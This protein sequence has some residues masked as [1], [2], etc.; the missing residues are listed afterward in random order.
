MPYRARWKTNLVNAFPVPE[1]RKPKKKI[2]TGTEEEQEDDTGFKP[3]GTF[4]LLSLPAEVRTQIYN[5]ILFN[6][7]D[8]LASKASQVIDQR[9]I[10]PSCKN[11]AFLLLSKQV[12]SETTRLL[13]STATFR[14]FPIQ[15]FLGLPTLADIA[16]HYRTHITRLTITLGSSWTGPPASWKVTK[17][18]ARYLQRMRGVRV[19]RVFVTLD[20]TGD[21]FEKYRISYDFYTDF[22]GELLREVLKA[23]PKALEMVE[24][25]GYEHVEPDGPLVSRLA[26]EA[27]AKEKVV[28]Y[29]QECGWSKKM[30]N[31]KGD[32]RTLVLR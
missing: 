30:E 32:R 10:L 19:L 2:Q 13:Y 7:T 6:E 22:C 26:K 24:L 25:S 8:P 17:G 29:G 28:L 18:L 4:P 21:D 9:E 14:L 15:D 23:M 3:K 11:L 5:L 16:P 27:I 12:H 31:L 20:P 1:D